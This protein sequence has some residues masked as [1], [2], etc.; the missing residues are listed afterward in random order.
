M[1]TGTDE[2]LAPD[3]KVYPTLTTEGVRV[4]LPPLADDF[5]LSWYNSGLGLVWQEKVEYGV[6]CFG[7]SWVFEW[8]LFCGFGGWEG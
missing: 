8:G 3:Y 7:D 4:E 2:T 5:R 1:P 6:V